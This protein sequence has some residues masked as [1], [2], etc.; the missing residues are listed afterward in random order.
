MEAHPLARLG[1]ETN[2][3]ETH[4]THECSPRTLMSIQDLQG[5]ADQGSW[6]ALAKHAGSVDVNSSAADA[7]SLT[8]AAY[9]A[10]SL[11]RLRDVHGLAALMRNIKSC[12]EPWP[13]V[14]RWCSANLLDQQGQ[15]MMAIRQLAIFF[16]SFAQPSQ[17]TLQSSLPSM[18][19]QCILSTMDF[20]STSESPSNETR[21]R[22]S[23][24]IACTIAGL[25]VRMKDTVSALQW[26][27]RAL[28][29]WPHNGHLMSQ[30]GLMLA[31]AGDAEGAQIMFE[32]ADQTLQASTVMARQHAGVLLFMQH[33]YQ[34]SLVEFEVAAA[35]DITY[36]AAANNAAVCRLYTKQGSRAA[37]EKLES[38]MKASA[39]VLT[40]PSAVS[41]L[42]LYAL[43]SKTKAASAKQALATWALNASPEDFN[44]DCLN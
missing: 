13:F 41:L 36:A 37:M 32:K 24:I 28:Q 34:A 17:Q 8:Y 42:S 23:V 35:A 19:E 22:Y 38:A 16:D 21:L 20:Q 1:K 27:Q 6:S 11:S 30:A 40:E 10:L 29:L 2:T 5:L 12:S 26:M 43:S 15:Q 3:A 33:E 25:H 7:Q 14:L 39:S 4:M 18:Q 44:A 9:H 31:A